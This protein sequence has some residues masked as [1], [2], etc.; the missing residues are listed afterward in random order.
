MGGFVFK[1]DFA[2]GLVGGIPGWVLNVTSGG[3]SFVSLGVEVADFPLVINFLTGL[4]PGFSACPS[5][6]ITVQVTET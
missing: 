5:G 4:G 3:M 2:C 1:L 6:T